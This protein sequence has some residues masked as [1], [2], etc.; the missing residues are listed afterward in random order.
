[1]SAEN[2]SEWAVTATAVAA[3]L[4]LWGCGA[5]WAW[6]LV[7]G[8][9]ATGLYAVTC[10]LQPQL[11]MTEVTRC[12]LGE[13][14]GGVVLWMQMTALALGA[15]WVLRRTGGII[16]NI[17]DGY[18]WIPVILGLLALAG[19][20]RGRKAALAS[21]AVLFWLVVG[22]LGVVVVFA[23]PQIRLARIRPEG[24]P[25]QLLP[26]L[27]LAL[28]PVLGLYCRKPEARR[29]SVALHLVIVL[30]AAAVV[31]VTTGCLSPR[32][33]AGEPLPFFT[34]AASC[35]LLGHAARFDAALCMTVSAAVYCMLILMLNYCR[36]LDRTHK[37]LPQALFVLQAL[38]ASWAVRWIPA[39][40][41]GAYLVLCWAIAPVFCAGFGKR[42][43]NAKK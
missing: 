22:T 31:F 7:G 5:S 40:W 32:L 14:L 4:L 16:P 1:M 37:S 24:A 19:S 26:S 38:G 3:P 15:G 13:R 28:L 9:L 23:L 17:A 35:R 2:R 27:L 30:T 43:K 36:Q 42:K 21:G 25:V 8:F 33:I 10:R 29:T 34:L 39:A 41:I 6:V 11:Q 18:P 12:V 20:C